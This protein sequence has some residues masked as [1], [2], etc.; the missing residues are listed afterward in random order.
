MKISQLKNKRILILGLGREGFDT[1]SFLRKT[2]FNKE[3]MIADKRVLD[4]FDINIQ[5]VIKKDKNLKLCLG[6]D[7]LNCLKDVE[8]IIKSPGINI[9]S[10]RK[11]L[12]EDVV[13]T[14]Q[15][16][17]FFDNCSAKIIGITGTKGKST[18]SSIIHGL[19]K[20]AGL[21]SYL[22]GNIEKPSLSYLSRITKDDWVVYELSC[23]QLQGLKKSPHIAVF[24]NL[25]PEHLDYYRN[26]KEYFLAKA[27]IFI[28]QKKN[29]YLVIDPKIR[30]VKEILKDVNSKVIEIV[31]INHMAFLN[32]NMEVIFQVTHNNNVVAVLEVAKILEIS[33][34]L[35]LKTLKKFKKLPHRLEY[36]GNY[37]DVNFY[38]DSIATIPESVVYALDVLGDE[39]ETLIV[40]GLNR[41]IK[42][43]VLAKRI[44]TSKVK[45]IVLFPDSGEEVKKEI[46][47]IDKDSSIVFFSTD[48]MREAINFAFR[49][50]SKGKICLLSPASPSFNIFKDY[51]ERGDMFKRVIKEMADEKNNKA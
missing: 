1:Y 35:V 18:T 17:I 6:P 42:F 36:A 9:S 43:G 39:V 48:Q 40:G 38:D 3:L 25:Y 46:L 22:L 27:N 21:K 31:P 28:N 5:M 24:L 33:E 2:F 7:Y 32:E 23:H 41:G 19:L 37:L 8:V 16:E 50:T 14:S 30:Q 20:N 45:N 11:Y 10:I 49:K 29:D 51:K 44:V 13:L 15:T 4:D 12:D 34:K 47:A 26:I